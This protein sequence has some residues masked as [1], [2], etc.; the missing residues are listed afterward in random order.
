MHQEAIHLRLWQ[1]I[2]AF[3]LDRV[4]RRHDHEHRHELV[5]LACHGNLAFLHRLEKRCLDFRRRAVDLVGQDNV[6][7]D[8][9][10]LEDKPFC[11]VLAEIHFRARYIGWQ[12]VGCELDAAEFRFEIAG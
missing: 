11:G 12:Q 9:A 7:E 3:L 10:G 4:L 2:G 8:R 5:G 6:C 1:G